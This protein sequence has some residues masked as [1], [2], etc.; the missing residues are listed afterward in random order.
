MKLPIT[1]NREIPNRSLKRGTELFNK[2][3]KDLSRMDCK[4]TF[5]PFKLKENNNIGRKHSILIRFVI[6]WFEGYVAY[7]FSL[8]Y[9]LNADVLFDKS[10]ST[11][12]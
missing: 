10:P 3:Q 2:L 4:S 1:L 8:N 9:F 7:M 12:A 6:Y 5:C 11:Y